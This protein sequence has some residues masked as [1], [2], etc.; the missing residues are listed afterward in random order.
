MFLGDYHPLYN[1]L[2]EQYT[3][4]NGDFDLNGTIF[5]GWI[6]KG[7]AEE[8]YQNFEAELQIFHCNDEVRVGGF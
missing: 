2:D 1:R 3:D 7:L 8:E 4:I 5:S 6:S